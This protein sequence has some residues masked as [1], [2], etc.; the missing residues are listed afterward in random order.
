MAGRDDDPVG[1]RAGARC[2]RRS[3]PTAGRS[4]D[5]D[6]QVAE[7]RGQYLDTLA[8]WS[9]RSERPV[10]VTE[11]GADDAGAAAPAAAAGLGHLA[12]R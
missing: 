9:G 7:V 8:N 10:D 11:A 5:L 4:S 12:R 6:E 1:H 2:C 3:P